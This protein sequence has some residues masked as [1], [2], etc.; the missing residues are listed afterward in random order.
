MIHIPNGVGA[1]DFV[2][3]RQKERHQAEP[4]DQPTRMWKTLACLVG[5]MTGTA[6]FLGWLDPT[7][8]TTSDALPDDQIIR[9]A[10]SAVSDGV[11]IRRDQWQ[12]V[13]IVADSVLSGGALLSARAGGSD[14]HFHVARDGGAVQAGPWRD[15]QAPVPSEH[16]IRIRV[17]RPVEGEPMSPA[18]WVCVRA[19]VGALSEAMAPDVHRLPVRLGRGWE[20]VYGVERGSMFEFVAPDPTPG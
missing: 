1:A 4:M 2:S 7:P 16:T 15:Q 13:E 20:N 11:T 14:S 5:A 6:M 18:Q 17:S 3:Q 8:T 9:L 12:E 19:L 10:R